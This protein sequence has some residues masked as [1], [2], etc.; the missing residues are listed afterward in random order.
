MPEPAAVVAEPVV[1]KCRAPGFW[2]A[3]GGWA[4][5]RDEAGPHPDRPWKLVRHGRV[6]EWCHTVRTAKHTA[7][8]PQPVTP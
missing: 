7:N 6:V 1:F 2:W 4:I 8:H 3:P 5:V